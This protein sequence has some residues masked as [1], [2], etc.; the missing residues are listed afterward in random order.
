MKKMRSDNYFFSYRGRKI[1]LAALLLVMIAV[2]PVVAEVN[3]L[4]YS[5]YF[6]GSGQGLI[7]GISLDSSKNIYICGKTNGGLPIVNG[8]Q[9]TYGGSTDAYVAKLSPDGSTILFSTYLGGSGLDQANGIA[10]DP[11]GNIYITGTTKSTNF[12]IRN[13]LQASRAGTG[14]SSADAFVTKLDPTGS[15]IYST[16]LGGTGTSDWGWAIS[17]DSSGDAYITGLTNSA[18]FPVI[19]AAQSVSGGGVDTFVTKINP[20]GSAYGYSTYLG[21]SGTDG[22]SSYT[23][24]IKS[25]SAGDAYVAGYTTSTNFPVLNAIQ[26]V[27]GG[28]NDAF[29]AKYSSSGS[30]VYAT[31]LGGS[32]LERATGIAIDDQGA[33][34]VTGYVTSSNFPVTSGAYQPAISGTQDYFISKI[35]PS[36]SSLEYSTYLGGPA[37]YDYGGMGIAVDSDHNA[38]VI[39]QVSTTT[40]FPL[41]DALQSTFGGGPADFTVSKLNPQGSALLFSTYLG[42]SAS[43]VPYDITV[44]NNGIMYVAGGTGSTNF[45]LKNPLQ[46]SITSGGWTGALTIIGAPVTAPIANFT[47]TPLSGPA[48]MTVQF[49]DASTS[50]AP[51]TYE[52]DFDSDGNVDSTDPNPQFTYNDP[53]TY[54]IS[55]TA[56]NSAGSDTELKEKYITVEKGIAAPEFPVVAFPVMVIS[57]FAFLAMVYRKVDQESP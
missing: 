42:G 56:I 49:T 18:D 45:P 23:M 55:L 21:G 22:S 5:T 40:T 51:L 36:G 14:D 12:P 6:G 10:L 26:S 57:A 38:Y 31:Y 46:S 24:R 25:D 53:G 17:A 11:S 30:K 37:N 48:P 20:D 29:I 44:D 52:W 47:A 16:Y 15:V 34:Y 32:S 27:S 3:E 13:P 43:D 33:A 41:V 7:Y 19:N 54:N 1:I 4:K 2:V 39:G 8:Y 35:N 50:N 28:G 9:S